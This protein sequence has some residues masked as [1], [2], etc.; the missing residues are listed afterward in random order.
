MYWTDGRKYIG[1][2]KAGKQHGLGTY[3]K[4]DGS[5]RNGEWASG[6]KI[7]WID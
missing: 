3:V 6:K 5:Q 1:N 7:R 2:W 4:V